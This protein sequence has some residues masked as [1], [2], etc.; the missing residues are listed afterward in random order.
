[1]ETGKQYDHRLLGKRRSD[2]RR[3]FKHFRPKPGCSPASLKKFKAIFGKLVIRWG[4][5]KSYSEL[6]G[7]RSVTAYEIIASDSESV[8][9]RYHDT[10][11]GD[12]RLRQIHFDGDD[13]WIALCGGLCEYFRRVRI[14][15]SPKKRR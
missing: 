13:Y 10:L 6:D 3:T 11:A 9:I 4:R 5:G 7:R 12:D 2:R 8:V 14:G 15:D 1:M